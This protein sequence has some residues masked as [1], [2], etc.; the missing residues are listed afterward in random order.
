MIA[1]II[2]RWKLKYASPNDQ[3]MYESTSILPGVLIFT[4]IWA[5]DL[6]A[7]AKYLQQKTNTEYDPIV[8]PL[9]V[10]TTLPLSLTPFQ[11][12]TVR[13]YPHDTKKMP[14]T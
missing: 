5:S 14:S 12:T 9:F 13:R 3:I 2:F 7:L 10:M 11:V 6:C 1:K 8:S 4:E